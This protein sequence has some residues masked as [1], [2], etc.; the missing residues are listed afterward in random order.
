MFEILKF[1]DSS[2]LAI[3]CWLKVCE[4]N[5][6]CLQ[7]LC[8]E[9]AELSFL[10]SKNLIEPHISLVNQNLIRTSREEVSS[11]ERSMYKEASIRIVVEDP[12]GFSQKLDK[13]NNQQTMIF[14]NS[15]GN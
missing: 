14:P 12:Y 5:S 4:Q 6:E 3:N 13:K 9:T 7:R 8:A 11:K 2:V 15:I 10:K 1:R